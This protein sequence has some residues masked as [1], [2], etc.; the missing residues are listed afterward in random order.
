VTNLAAQFA[1]R[2]TPGQRISLVP[3]G[4]LP[5]DEHLHGI[6]P[7]RTYVL[8]GAP[9]TGK[10]VASMQFLMAALKQGERVA[11]LTQDDPEDLLAQSEYLGFDL[12]GAVASDQLAFLRFQLDF[13]RRFGRSPSPE[14]A[15][16]E[17]RKLLGAAPPSRIVID[18][19]VPFIDGGTSSA[20]STIALLQL[21]DELGATSFITYPGDL[22]GAYDRRLDPLVQRAA[23]ILHLTADRMRHRQIEIR[24]VR[25]R[26]PS[27][28]PIPYRIEGGAGI[29]MAAEE[30]RWQNEEANL[31][32]DRQ[33][34]VLDLPS[35]AA[36]EA[37]RLLQ[38]HYS[39]KV[40]SNSRPTPAAP[41]TLIPSRRSADLADEEGGDLPD[42]PVQPTRDGERVSFDRAGFNSAVS[43]IIADDPR[44]LF[45]IV[46]ITPP[47]GLLGPLAG[48][49]LRTVRAVNGDLVAATENQVLI[50]LHGTGRK[51]ARY[52]VERLTENWKNAGAG[53]LVVDVL[54]YP[55]DHDRIRT[56]L[57][58]T[59]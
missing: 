17:L 22:A 14:P 36:T 25:Y 26:V 58:P 42:L 28:S 15:F 50:Y 59:R 12:A 34:F 7:G 21:L 43:D 6:M 33:R 16:A 46:A 5:I 24:K 40:V 29:V 19:V 8:S 54:G 57:S 1:D 41:L 2:P 23:A 31:P 52:F 49:S 38:S 4:I 48:V 20:S 13:S 47:P 39:V 45:A 51:H 10:S 11:I 44:A 32:G 56:L 30:V 35:G 18:S 3:S 9:G 27:V 37:L 55:S 53:E